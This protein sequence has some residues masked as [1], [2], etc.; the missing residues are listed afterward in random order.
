M[1]ILI[2]TYYYSPWPN[3]RAIRWT[4]LANAFASQGN[5]IDVLCKSKNN[6]ISISDNNAINLYH[7]DKRK[8]QG[9]KFYDNEN[10][11]KNFFV[12]KCKDTILKLL[13]IIHSFTWKKIYWPDHACFWYFRALKVGRKLLNNNQYDLII[14]VSLPYTSHLV[15]LKLRAL[16]PNARWIVDI[17]DPFYFLSSTPT[18]NHSIYKKLNYYSEKN[19]LHSADS[20]SVTNSAVAV[21]YRDLFPEC[22]N[23]IHVIPPVLGASNKV[24]SPFFEDKEKIILVYIG[25]LYKN[26]R[27]PVPLLKILEYLDKTELHNKLE[28]HIVGTIKDCEK[29][30]SGNKNINRNIF[31][32]GVVDNKAV[33]Q[34][35]YDDVFLINIGNKTSYQLPSK[36]V[37]YISSGNPIINIYSNKH[38]SSME[39][40]KRYPLK[41]NVDEKLTELDIGKIK[42]YIK[43]HNG[44]RVDED[45]IS[46]VLEPF[47]PETVSKK[48]LSLCL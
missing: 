14:S 21:I 20:I 45:E 11:Y 15:A 22:K 6:E 7:T 18:N 41:L 8:N 48:Y 9:E 37:E 39:F 38:D 36:I 26:I 35:L 24:C 43:E 17:G 30:F 44:D 5:K 29:Y 16:Q 12:C 31:L 13:K 2:I 32:H 19:V 1:R 42:N 33:N 25:T 34:F 27:S 40:L 46:K 23:K 3:P 10:Y 4:T 28:L 47:K